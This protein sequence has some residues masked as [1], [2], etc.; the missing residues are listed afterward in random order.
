MFFSGYPQI[1]EYRTSGSVSAK[2][3][4]RLKLYFSLAKAP[5]GRRL[6]TCPPLWCQ[7]DH[8]SLPGPKA[9]PPATKAQPPG[10]EVPPPA[11]NA[12]P[13]GPEPP[14]PGPKV[15]LTAPGLP[16]ASRA[17]RLKDAVISKG[18]V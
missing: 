1:N 12:Q 16:Q 4:T 2:Y 13:P 14:S 9:Q 5:C 15:P 8:P 6:H 17:S 7:E 10:H 3:C 18:D 11:T